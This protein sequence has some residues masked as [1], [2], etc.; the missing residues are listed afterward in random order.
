MTCLAA[1]KHHTHP[2][3]SPI[4]LTS[5]D[6]MWG[7]AFQFFAVFNRNLQALDRQPIKTILY[8]VS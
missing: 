5:F 1:T 6:V 8:R 3:L 4:A 2:T 7:L